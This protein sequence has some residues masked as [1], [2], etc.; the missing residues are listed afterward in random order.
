M[1][2]PMA[3]SPMNAKEVMVRALREMLCRPSKERAVTTESRLGQPCLTL[4]G[5]GEVNP[6]SRDLLYCS[7]IQLPRR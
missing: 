7:V 1:G 4:S 2:V 3:P 5:L 6:I